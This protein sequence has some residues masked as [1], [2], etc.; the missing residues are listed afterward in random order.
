ME[1]NVFICMMPKPK[2]YSSMKYKEFHGI[3]AQKLS[4]IDKKEWNMEA[5]WKDFN[6]CKHFGE[7]SYMFIS[8]SE[9]G[10]L[11]SCYL[12]MT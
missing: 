6:H 10:H 11:T 9:I 5:K 1:Q 8:T 3:N 2:A 4:C 7:E 12:C